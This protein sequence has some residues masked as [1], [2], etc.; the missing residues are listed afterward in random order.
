MKKRR[1]SML[2]P[3]S[4]ASPSLL[5]SGSSSR[6]PM[7]PPDA[8][9]WSSN[10]LHALMDP[11]E[12]AI[13]AMIPFEGDGTHPLVL[14]ALAVTAKKVDIDGLRN[15]SSGAPNQGRLKTI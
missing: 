12:V 5:L 1:S 15:P 2:V 10:D 13:S 7:E 9:D 8:N 14:A 11:L 3:R 6:S 4:L